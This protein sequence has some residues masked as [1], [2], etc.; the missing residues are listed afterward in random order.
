MNINTISLEMTIEELELQKKLKKHEYNR[1]YRAKHG[2]YA[3][4]KQYI[5]EYQKRRNANHKLMKQEIID[6]KQQI[7]IL[8]S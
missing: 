1:A 6:L 2:N 7:L 4:N 8:S 5:L 3:T